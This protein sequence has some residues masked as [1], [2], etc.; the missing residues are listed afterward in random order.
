MNCGRLPITVMMRIYLGV[1]GG[2]R[3]ILAGRTAAGLPERARRTLV[4]VAGAARHAAWYGVYLIDGRRGTRLDERA[5][6]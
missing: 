5:D 2:Q 4:V 3:R 6:E 1:G